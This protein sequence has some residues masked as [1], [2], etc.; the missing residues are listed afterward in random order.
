MEKW[1]KSWNH[2][3]MLK[4]AHVSYGFN[5]GCRLSGNTTEDERVWGGTQWGIGNVGSMLVPGGIPGPSHSD[6]IMDMLETG[7]E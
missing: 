1:L 4:L 2:P 6:G 7:K 3:Q 5:P